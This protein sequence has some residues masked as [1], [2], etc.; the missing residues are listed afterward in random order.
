MEG[1][2]EEVFISKLYAARC[3]RAAGLPWNTC[4]ELWLKAHECD[5]SRIEPLADLTKEYSGMDAHASCVLFGTR[6]MALP[7]PSD[8]ALFV[9]D[10]GYLVAHHVG[11]HAYYLPDGHDMGLGACKRAIALRPN[12]CAADVRNLALYLQRGSRKKLT[13]AQVELLR[14]AL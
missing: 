5:P 2:K 1:F 3:A 10:W 11:W 14:K 6:A 13:P 8:S 9:E 4:V 12:D 7:P